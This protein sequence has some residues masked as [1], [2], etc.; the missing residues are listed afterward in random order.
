MAGESEHRL[1]SRWG[2]CVRMRMFSGHSAP[3]K[4]EEKVKV[5]APR[6]LLSALLALSAFLNLSWLTSARGLS[7]HPRK[8]EGDVDNGQLRAGS[9]GAVAIVDLEIIN[10]YRAAIRLRY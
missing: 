8:E 5:P 4:R 7:G 3:N 2:S 1:E 6:L 10:F 9:Q